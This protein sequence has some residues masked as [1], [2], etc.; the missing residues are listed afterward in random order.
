L[1]HR[2]SPGA[3]GRSLLQ[4]SDRRTPFLESL[5]PCRRAADAA[6]DNAGKIVSAMH[7]ALVERAASSRNAIKEGNSRLPRDKETL[8]EAV[9]EGLAS[10]GRSA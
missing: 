6:I 9:V 10:Y 8:A 1:T 7:M 2:K 4:A 5:G 3:P